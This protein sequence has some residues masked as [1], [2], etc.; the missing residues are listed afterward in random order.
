MFNLYAIGAAAL[1]VVGLGSWGALETRHASSLEQKIGTLNSQ[2]KRDAEA[3]KTT[4]ASLDEA[5]AAA[6]Q[7][8]ATCTRSAG[9]LLV[10]QKQA[11]DLQQQLASRRESF[12]HSQEKDRA[13]PQCQ[14]IMAM[15]LAAACPDVAL[16]LRG[17]PAA[18]SGNQDR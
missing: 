3:L 1:L 16:Q 8:K 14:K 7:W 6:G 13:L 9:E 4:N 10:A 12:T 17:L 2:H 15:D 18:G 5:V 11:A